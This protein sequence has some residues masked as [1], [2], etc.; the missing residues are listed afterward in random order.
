MLYFKGS[1]SVENGISYYYVIL[2]DVTEIRSVY[3]IIGYRTS[4]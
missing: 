1:L 3:Q 4:L 2:N